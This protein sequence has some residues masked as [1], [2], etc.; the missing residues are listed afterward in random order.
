MLTSDRAARMC[1]ACAADGY[2]Y[3]SRVMPDGAIRRRR[4]C[5]QNRS[6]GLAPPR[7]T[8][9]YTAHYAGKQKQCG[10][11]FHAL[12]SFR[13]ARRYRRFG[14][15]KTIVRKKDGKWSC[16]KDHIDYIKHQWYFQ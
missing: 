5:A 7:A 9:A 2:V 10:P 1:P 3:D 8:N 14:R 12:S 4:R 6:R 13:A 11:L 16:F 15:L